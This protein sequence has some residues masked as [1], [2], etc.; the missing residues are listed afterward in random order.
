VAKVLNVKIVKQGWPNAGYTN[1]YGN[2][3]DGTPVSY[4]GVHRRWEWDCPCG[5]VN[6]TRS[7]TCDD[8]GADRTKVAG[9]A[10]F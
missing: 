8:C 3:A 2:L 1:S 9:K 6:S 10:T 4:C 5:H 7:I